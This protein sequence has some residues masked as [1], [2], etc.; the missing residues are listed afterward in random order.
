M[1]K[2]NIALLTTVVILLAVNIT[3]FVLLSGGKTVPE[4]D[5]PDN[6]SSNGDGN[7]SSGKDAAVPDTSGGASIPDPGGYEPIPESGN[8]NYGEAWQKA[9]LFYEL[10]RSGA[11][12]DEIR[13]NWR[14]ASALSDGEDVGIDLTG[15]WYDAGDHVKFNLPMAYSATMLAW[16]V[17]EDKQ[18]YIAGGELSHI[19]DSIRWAN[20]YFIKCHPEPEVYYYQVGDGGADHSWWGPAEAMQMKRPA[21]KVDKNNPGSTVSAAAAAA[22]ASCAVVYAEYDAYYSDLCVKHAEELFAFAETTKSDAGY[23]AANGFYQSWSGW[24]DELASAAFWLYKATNEKSYLDKAKSYV[25]TAANGDYYTWAHCWDNVTAGTALLLAMETGDSKYKDMIEKNLDFWTT[26]TGGEKIRYTP[27]GLAW[28]D[29]WGSLRYA[30]T[31]SYLA[32]VYS[33]WSG[34]PPAKKTVYWDFAV[35]QVDYA[36]GSTGRSFV[37]GFGENPPVNPHHRTAQGS[38]TDNM[39]NPSP[40][41]HVL[42][43]ALVGGPG[44]NDDYSDDVG[45]YVNNEVACDYNAGFTAALAKMYGVYGGT[46]IAD[47]N[48][49]EKKGDEL[50]VEAGVNAAGDNFVEIKAVVYNQTGW[51]ARVTENLKIRYFFDLSEI[52]G[53]A[54][55]I[56]VNANYMQGGKISEVKRWKDDIYYVEIDFSGYKIYPGGQSQYKCEVQFR[57][58]SAG[59]WDNG[60]DPSYKDMGGSGQLKKAAGIALYEGDDLAFGEEP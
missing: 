56:G 50:F 23:T 36:L 12:P 1:K 45:N 52:S 47:L 5:A 6:F 26:G 43:G 8:Y 27:K 37:C 44:N 15:G 21:H 24:N 34:C 53:D 40:G 57:M 49:V 25:E 4:I 32:G 41:R 33:Q 39:N 60:N 19:L 31:M 13:T 9:I 18:S 16:S 48:A 46:L 10:Q 11:L 42:T 51:P 14:G 17:Y 3:T 30:T 29:Q 28:L 22:L 59:A 2:L 7:S 20:D 54:S 58:T 55:A 38:W 35:S